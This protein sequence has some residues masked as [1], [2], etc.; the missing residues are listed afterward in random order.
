MFDNSEQQGRFLRRN[1]KRNNKQIKVISHKTV[2][3]LINLPVLLFLKPDD[4]HM[5]LGQLK[6]M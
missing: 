1:N 4:N 2:W 6:I 5:P 3:I